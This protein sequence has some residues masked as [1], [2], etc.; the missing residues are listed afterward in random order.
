[1]ACNVQA[2]L[3]VLEHV[4]ALSAATELA[5]WTELYLWLGCSAC[6]DRTGLSDNQI[7]RSCKRILRRV[8]EASKALREAYLQ[9]EGVSL[10]LVCAKA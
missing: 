1:M 8:H 5:E 6:H 9:R 10:L 4:I 3:A 7:I 2:V